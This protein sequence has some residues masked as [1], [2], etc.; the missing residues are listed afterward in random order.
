MQCFHRSYFAVIQLGNIS[1]RTALDT[2]SSDAWLISSACTTSA[3]SVPKYQLAYKSPSF[4][5]VNNNQTAFNVSFADGTFANG[6]V[7]LETF[8]VKNLT[9]PNQG[10]GVVSHSNLSFTDD[11]SGLLGLGFPRLS[12][13][14]NSVPSLTPFFATMAQRGQL[15][16]PLFGLNLGMNTSDTGSLTFGAVDGS[17]VSNISSIVWNEVMPFAPFGSESNASSYL[18]WTIPMG[19]LTVNGTSL[20]PIPTYSNISR[21]S[22]ALFDVGT[23]G[24]FGPFQDVSR[25]YSAIPG[26]RLVDE[27]GQWVVPCDA[28]ETI[29]F[30]FGHKIFLMQPTDYLIGPSESTP[31]LCL[32][33]P[34]ARAPTSDGIDWQLGTP[35]LRTVYSIFSFGIDTKEAPMIGLFPLRNA[36]APVQSPDEVASFFSAASATVSTVLPNFLLSTPSPTTPPY[37]FNTSVSVSV[38]EIVSSGLATST[39]SPAIGSH[40]VNATAIPTLAPSPTLATFIL[41]SDGQLVTSVSTAASPSITLGTPPGWSNGSTSHARVT[42]GTAVF[43]AFVPLFLLSARLVL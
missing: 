16:Y 4:V 28:N 17:V 30:S 8:Q 3:C 5:T 32:S 29:S 22:L 2:G 11:I 42:L 43:A 6:F 33:W 34:R 25:I 21:N 31:D 36:T 1:F 20:T 10:F 9:V 7:A 35:F 12:T 39:Y 27:A 40:H 19:N 26:S 23:S 14:F 13:I 41:T 24:I 15:E 37:A 18:Q 38:G